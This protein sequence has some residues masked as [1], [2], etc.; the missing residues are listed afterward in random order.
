MACRTIAIMNQKGGVGKTTTVLNLGA[1]LAELGKRVLLVDLD[2]QANLT[3]GLGVEVAGLES[4]TYD[5]L[6][7][8]DADM[9]R[10]I[11]HTRW[12]RLDIAPSHIDLSG[13]EIEMVPMYGREVRLANALA[14]V[15]DG[16]DY[17]LIDCLPSLSLLTVNAMVAAS[18]IFVPMQAHPFA[19]EGLGKLF[20]V[21]ELIR[22]QM[23]PRLRLT[24]VLVTMFNTRTNV[25][26]G[27]MEA[28]MNDPRT[29]DVVFTTIVRQNIR[30]AESQGLGVPV[31]HYDRTC[32]G[33]V[34][35]RELAKE[36]MFME[37][38]VRRATATLTEAAPTEGDE[39]DTA[40]MAA[41]EIQAALSGGQSDERDGDEGDRNE[42]A[43]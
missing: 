12:E 20:E 37:V 11:Q 18:E 10:I 22:G 3:L 16:Y 35:Y 41:A 23:N 25:S 29:D 43:A 17:V 31:I 34:A 6:T 15:S 33:A 38:A 42:R 2:P 4:S 1:A 5:V 8:P 32:H 27:V 9:N 26:K 13:A 28:L 7:N 21:Y 14:K 30:I 39:D 36:V 40:Q 19:L 24:G